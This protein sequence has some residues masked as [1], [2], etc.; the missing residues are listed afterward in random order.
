MEVG[1]GV[2]RKSTL[3]PDFMGLE[4]LAGIQFRV[5]QLDK[6][7]ASK[8][9]LSQAIAIPRR[10]KRK[11]RAEGRPFLLSANRES[12]NSYGDRGRPP[13][14][15]REAATRCALRF[16]SSSNAKCRV[17]PATL[18]LR[19]GSLG[20]SSKSAFASR[21]F[22]CCLFGALLTP[23]RHARPVMSFAA[24]ARKT[25]VFVSLSISPELRRRR[26]TQA[27]SVCP[28]PSPVMPISSM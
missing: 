28:N 4:E 2:G 9:R 22:R 1:V 15:I 14:A 19:A 11:G 12:T 17:K 27:T 7:K 6:P 25:R 10:P 20:F 3:T 23:F 18:A 21:I 13:L 26:P 24:S 5:T 8:R 16:A